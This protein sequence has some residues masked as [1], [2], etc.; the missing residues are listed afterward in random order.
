NPD[1]HTVFLDSGFARGR[2]PRN[3]VVDGRSAPPS[4]HLCAGGAAWPALG[5]EPP[6]RAAACAEAALSPKVA[7]AI[8]PMPASEPRMLIASIGSMT[9]F[10]FGDSA[11]CPNALMY[12]SAMK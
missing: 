3:D 6:R 8:S 9:I 10:W 11:S 12:L 5:T 4:S 2:A 7:L 1:P